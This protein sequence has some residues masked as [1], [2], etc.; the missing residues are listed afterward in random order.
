MKL[1]TMRMKINGR[2]KVGGKSAVGYCSVGDI[3]H[4]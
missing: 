1:K 4:L 3:G 2:A